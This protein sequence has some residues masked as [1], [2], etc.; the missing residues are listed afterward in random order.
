MDIQSVS[1]LGVCTF[2][3]RL[4]SPKK[5]RKRLQSYLLPYI[6][7]RRHARKLLMFIYTHLDFCL[8]WG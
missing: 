2:Y 7:S 6:H 5:D 1:K 3:K 8:D 4:F